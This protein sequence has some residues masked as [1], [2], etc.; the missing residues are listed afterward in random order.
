MTVLDNRYILHQLIGRGGMGAVYQATDRLNG[1]TVALKRVFATQFEDRNRESLAREFRTLATLRHPHIVSVLDY[2]FDHEQQPYFTMEYLDNARTIFEAAHNQTVGERVWLLIQVLLALA[3]LHRRSILHRDL[4]PGNVLV[5]NGRVKVVDFGL[6]IQ[7]QQGADLA[8]TLSYMAPEVLINQPS[9]AASDLYAVGVMAYELLAGRHPFNV[10][11]MVNLRTQILSTL[12]DLSVLE[13][14]DSESTATPLANT[15]FG[16]SVLIETA[17]LEP[18]MPTAELL[19][20]TLVDAEA[21]QPLAA[22]QPPRSLHNLAAIVG[23]LLSKD[24]QYRYTDATSVIHDFCAAIDQ[25]LPEETVDLRESFLQAASFIGRE[26][27]LQDLELAL[28]DM[29]AGKGSTWLIGGESGVGK[30]RLLEEFRIL[31]L[32]RGALVVTGQMIAEKTAPYYLWREPIRQ[33]LLRTELDPIEASVLRRIIPDVYAL[34]G[35]PVSDEIAV[36]DGQLLDVI[37]ALFRRQNQPTVLMVEDLQWAGQNLE[38]LKRL[39]MISLDQTLMVIGS[40]RGEAIPEIDLVGSHQLLLTPFAT[41]QIEAITTAMLGDT[42]TD[43]VELLERETSG[44]VFLVVELV[45]ALAEEAGRLSDIS[46]MALPERIY[47]GGPEVILKRYLKHVPAWGHEVLRLA[48]VNGRNLDFNVLAQFPPEPY[49]EDWLTYFAFVCAESGVFEVWEGQW[50]FAHDKLRE[51]ILT[52]IPDTDTP[53]Y[54]RQVALALEAAYPDSL[55]YTLADHW[56]A[57]G[58]PARA[59]EYVLRAAQNALAVGAYY[60]VIAYLNRALTTELLDTQR[61]GLLL[62]LGEAYRQVKNIDE[63]RR[64][65]EQV[66]AA[67]DVHSQLATDA[68]G[69][70]GQLDLVQQQ[71]QQARER[72]EA[73][74]TLARSLGATRL[75]SRTLGDMGQLYDEQGQLDM[76][77]AL[78]RQALDIAG[79]D[80][81]LNATH[82]QRLAALMVAQGQHEQATYF[83]Q[84]ALQYWRALGNRHLEAEMLGRLGLLY[85]EMGV[86]ELAVD[87]LQQAIA[88]EHTIGINHPRLL[89]YL[90]HLQRMLGRL[91]E[92][93]DA[94]QQAVNLA[95]RLQEDMDLAYTFWGWSL[96]ST[97]DFEGAGSAFQ[98][99]CHVAQT[100]PDRLDA[101]VG[102]GIAALY[103][104]NDAEANSAFSEAILI[105]PTQSL[106]WFARGLA[107]AGLVLLQQAETSV[108][109]DAYQQAVAIVKRPGLLAAEFQKLELMAYTMRGDLT[110]VA[111]VLMNAT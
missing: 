96:M 34:T 16:S 86:Y 85:R 27:E 20:T 8:G 84:N 75:E 23:K 72:L 76:A 15:D 109:I 80:K 111:L 74:L 83:A 47:F 51:S 97:R 82:L 103:Q 46:H 92:A 10:H 45:R 104:N 33:L 79:D 5:V 108:A 87:Y 32:V 66:L 24:P 101:L 67:A 17:A 94:G 55:N 25:P 71:W 100:L 49:R 56:E 81:R 26:T 59:L 102:L 48:A 98:T 30:S 42:R 13:G 2:G 107:Y 110:P 90:G 54:H 64:L 6:A 53:T 93:L 91:P 21:P 65:Y 38:I 31:A 77:L 9:T 105:Q 1:Q 95:Q 52:L 50:R 11:D 61:L 60:D 14:L 40:Y 19:P 68:L 3:Y 4:K 70:L 37:A 18:T 63:S 41:P 36:D 7:Q 99:A 58:E 89:A 22:P 62:D 35:L 57:A 29:L 78:Y 88:L 69:R 44:N 73:C 43:M 12:P 28:D 106:H 39:S